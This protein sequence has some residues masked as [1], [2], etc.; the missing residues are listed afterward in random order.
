M[1]GR[2]KVS[3]KEKH[4]L[5]WPS[6]LLV[7][8]SSGLLIYT[9]RYSDQ[10]LTSHRKQDSAISMGAAASAMCSLN[11]GFSGADDP[12]WSSL[13]CIAVKPV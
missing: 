13:G 7:Y 8:S 2:V 5:F 6:R 9:H 12:P 11:D 10:S 3:I 4:V 1:L